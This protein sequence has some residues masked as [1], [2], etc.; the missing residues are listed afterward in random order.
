M[1][2]DQNISLFGL[3]LDQTSKSHL[4][5]AARWAKFLAIMGFIVCVLIALAGIFAG[6]FFEEYRDRYE[7]FG[8]NREVSTRGLGAIAAVFYVLVA[9][10]YFFPCLF[11]FNFASKMKSALLSNDQN[12]LNRSFQNLKKT[13]RY[14]GVLTIIVLCFWILGIVVALLGRNVSG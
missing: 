1:E 4:S 6:S 3:N 14:V 2:Q 11:L 12:V 13:F 10:L 9:L 8:R 7:G 5:E